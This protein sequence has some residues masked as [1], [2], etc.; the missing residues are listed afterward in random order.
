[1]RRDRRLRD[2]ADF[3]RVHRQG[4]SW[5]HPLLVLVAFSPGEGGPARVGVTASKRVGG[6]VVRNRVRRRLRAAVD[7][8]YEGIA[9]GWD[10]VIV[11]RP[12]AATASFAALEVALAG[13]LRRAGVLDSEAACAGSASV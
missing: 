12:A 4:R 2:P 5:S 1:M 9:A 6:A 3:E 11:A 8:R 13:L 7:A 10:I